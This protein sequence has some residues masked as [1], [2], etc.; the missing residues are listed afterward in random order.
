MVSKY[1]DPTVVIMSVEDYVESVLKV[2]ESLARLQADA[3]P[4]GG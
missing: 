1:G 4:A 2:P 3:R